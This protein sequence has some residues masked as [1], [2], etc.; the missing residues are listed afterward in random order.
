MITITYK[1]KTYKMQ[2]PFPWFEWTI[3]VWLE[4]GTLEEV[5]ENKEPQFTPW[6]EEP[7]DLF[8]TCKCDACK[9]G[10]AWLE[11]NMKE[12]TPIEGEEIEVSNDGENWERKYFQRITDSDLTDWCIYQVWDTTITYVPEFWKFAR[13]IDKIEQV[14]VETKSIPL[15]TWTWVRP[16]QVTIPEFFSEYV[17]LDTWRKVYPSNEELAKQ[18]AK[19]TRFLHSQFPNSKPK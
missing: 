19:I 18:V 11:P 15:D 1:G 5:K 12:W 13:P 8:T 17:Y 7:E 10:D 14:K 4:N 9:D 16:E 3:H 2:E 6:Q